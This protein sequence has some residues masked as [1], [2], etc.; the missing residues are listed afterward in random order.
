MSDQQATAA[1][2]EALGRLAVYRDARATLHQD[3]RAALAAG[4]SQAD[5]AR[6]SG[7][8]RQGVAKITGKAASPRRGNGREGW[9]KRDDITDAELVAIY[10]EL[11]SLPAVGRRV[12]MSWVTVR[13][14]IAA[15]GGVILPKG[16]RPAV[17]PSGGRPSGDVREQQLDTVRALLANDPGMSVQAVMDAT[18]W[19]HG[20]ADTR[21]TAVHVELVRAM[22]DDH[23]GAAAAD[24]A[25]RLG[26][27]ID[28]AAR[29]LRAVKMAYE[30]ADDQA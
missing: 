18:G 12:G 21:R 16:Q 24:V 11:R 13:D 7:L 23:P 20:L 3:V 27:R 15:A 26:I 4:A 29:R 2:E 25:V 1:R 28:T 10:A 17:V 30:Q 5:V 14:R 8:T 22:L 19:S 9:R 6:A